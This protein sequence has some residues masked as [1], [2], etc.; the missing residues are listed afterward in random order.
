MQHYSTSI[1]NKQIL[2]S[3]DWNAMNSLHGQY[4]SDPIGFTFITDEDE[5]TKL[6]FVNF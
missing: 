5:L 3:I 2:T 1:E 6:T 4:L